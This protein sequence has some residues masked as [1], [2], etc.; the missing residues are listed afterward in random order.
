A[1]LAEFIERWDRGEA[2]RAEDYLER[3]PPGDPNRAVELI[4]QEFCLAELAG[5][6]PVVDDYLKRFPDQRESLGRLLGL[7]DAFTS[8]QLRDWPGPG[9]PPPEVGDEIGPY[10]LRRQLGRGGFARVF[11]AEQSD[12]DDRLVVVKVSTRLTPEP[13][14]LAR[15]RHSH[16]VEV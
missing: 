15:A 9:L 7:H 16:I 1:I 13:Q 4:Y 12:L 5:L 2:P 10:R 8:S 3:L 6:H 14:L 11:L